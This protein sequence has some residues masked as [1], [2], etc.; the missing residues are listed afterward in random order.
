MLLI[1]NFR[2][3]R[4]LWTLFVVWYFI[5]FS[6]NFFNSLNP[7]K[8]SIPFLFFIILVCWMGIEYYFNSPFWQSGIIV[9][10]KL[11]QTLLAIFL[12]GSAIYSIADY[13]A[14]NLTQLDFL[15]PYINILGIAIFLVGV[16]LRIY[17][18]LEL[19]K[20]PHQ[21]FFKIT[22]FQT[23]RHPR[24]LGT[25]LQVIAIPLIFSSYLGLVIIFVCLYLIYRIMSNEEKANEKNF[26]D[27]YLNYRQAVPFII[28]KFSRRRFAKVKSKR[29][30]NA[31]TK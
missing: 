31:R 14:L 12:Y 11:E 26:K 27:E 18:L 4:F 25:I 6:H 16:L 2:L 28:P 17:T 1:R 13:S 9:P 29:K 10:P 22:I 7:L 21:H 19:L 5:N 3:G 20:N 24:H 23:C 8:A 15:N 30:P